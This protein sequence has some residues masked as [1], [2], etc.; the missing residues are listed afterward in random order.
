MS[1]FTKEVVTPVTTRHETH[2]KVFA[3]GSGITYTLCD[4]TDRSDKRANYFLSFNLPYKQDAFP[5][6]FYLSIE[7]PELQQLN[8]DKM[9]MIDIN[10][11][12]YNEFIDGR[13]IKLTAPILEGSGSG[14]TIVS[15]EIFSTTYR[16][17]QKKQENELL[18]S[19]VSFLFCDD[20]NLP[21][22]GTTNDGNV[23]LSNQTTWKHDSNSL[24][25]NIYATSFVD[26]KTN[27]LNTDS[28]PFSGINFAVEVGQNYPNTSV[29]NYNY[30]IPVGF[31]AL[32][33]GFLVLTH[34]DLVENIAWSSGRTLDGSLNVTSGTSKIYF[35]N[36]DE[37]SID[38]VDIDINYTS[39]VMC[40]VMPGEFYR[41]TNPSYDLQ[42]AQQ[43][44]DSGANGMEPVYI[45]EIGL[46]NT[47]GEVI[48]YA[49][50]DRPIEKRYA[51]FISFTI[52][53]K[54]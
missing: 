30:D 15:K 33:K 11:S 27:D 36:S 21:Y 22:T 41:T 45:T 43:E 32:D 5:L 13:T 2:E 40:I 49:K 46:H 35:D 54:A 18:G 47:R 48:A 4:R 23:D 7:K 3:S 37:S 1:Q 52:D 26:V 25:K 50:L 19:N 6:D 28:R 14:A 9:V 42:R 38:F 53:L 8:V 51:D 10:A 39:S 20:I 34:P 12:F 17:L 16:S 29:Q 24:V 31:A 44:I